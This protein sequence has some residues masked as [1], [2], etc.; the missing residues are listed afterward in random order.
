MN[1]DKDN[2]GKDGKNLEKYGCLSFR[3]CKCEEEEIEITKRERNLEGVSNKSFYMPRPF[4]C[5]NQSFNQCTGQGRHKDER[6]KDD[7]MI[8]GTIFGTNRNLGFESW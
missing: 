5:P 3:C 8:K 4:S 2:Y 1:L 6:I 7:D